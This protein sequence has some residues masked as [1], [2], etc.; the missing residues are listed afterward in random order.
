MHGGGVIRPAVADVHIKINAPLAMRNFHSSRTAEKAL[1]APVSLKIRVAKAGRAADAEFAL[2]M[3][4]LR[5]TKYTKV[6]YDIWTDAHW[7]QA[8]HVHVY[9]HGVYVC[10]LG[11]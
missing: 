10:V 1:V 5:Q 4:K 11:E 3:H 2:L 6:F 9:V 8:N 7:I